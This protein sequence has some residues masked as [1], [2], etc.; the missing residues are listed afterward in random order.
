M[1][2]LKPCPFCSGEAAKSV[3]G[4][5]RCRQCGEEAWSKTKWQS[6]PIEAELLEALEAAQWCEYNDPDWGPQTLCPECRNS[7]KHGHHEKCSI[8][9]AIRKAKG[10]E[11]P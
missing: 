8:G 11:Q 7:K 10:E 5:I 9:V 1:S 4:R 6:R 2:K 3:T